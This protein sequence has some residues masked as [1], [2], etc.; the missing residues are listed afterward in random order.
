MIP[1]NHRLAERKLIEIVHSGTWRIDNQGRIW[2][3]DG[4]GERRAERQIPSGYLMVRAMRNGVRI[5]GLAHRLVW[6]YLHGDIPDG[7]VIN[8]KNG[9]KDDN[10]PENIEPVSYSENS[11]HAYRIGLMDEHGQRNPAAKLSDEQ[12]ERIR[13][14][15]ASGAFTMEE[16]G[17]K[18]GVRFQH[19]SRLVRGQRRVKQLGPVVGFDLRIREF[20]TRSQP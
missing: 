17:N 3:K 16:L 4:T 9:M 12:V 13:L 5:A 6:Q 18:F 1:S 19:I 20:P 15:Y 10:R 2:R 11:K 8:H 14:D 7:M